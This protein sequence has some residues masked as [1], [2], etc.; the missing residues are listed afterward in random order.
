MNYL[1][2]LANNNKIAY[3]TSTK[4]EDRQTAQNLTIRCVFN[5]NE[6]CN[7]GR[8]KLLIYSDSFLVLN[9]GTQ[10]CS[11]SNSEIPLQSLAITFD[12]NFVADFNSSITSST[13]RLLDDQ[14]NS[15][16]VPDLT[17]TLY[18]F[19]G[20]IKFT[21]MHLRDHLENGINDELLIN[22]YLHHCLITYNMLYNEEIFKKSEQLHISNKG[23]RI[24]MLRRLNLA[25]EYLYSNFDQPISLESLA[26]YACL[27][28]NHLLRTFK[29]A[30]GQSPHQFLIDLRLK[31]AQQ[32]LKTTDYPVNEVVSKVGFECT[33]SFIRL[34][35]KRMHTT[36]LI[37]RQTA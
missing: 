6:K 9:K 8:R 15:T 32:L 10:Y 29:L 18:P 25:K 23:A 14:Q 33:S 17:E 20:D 36:P 7:I 21:I 2:T 4:I 34:F 3:K 30:F 28:V 35:K 13:M 1:K 27:S 11:T 24:E 37:Y 19:Y 31:R 22:Q 12:Q 26:S 5:G 16:S